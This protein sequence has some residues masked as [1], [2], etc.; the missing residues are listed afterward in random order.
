MS[1]IVSS[2]GPP[3]FSIAADEINEFTL[4]ESVD[5]MHSQCEDTQN[6]RLRSFAAR[7]NTALSRKAGHN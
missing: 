3:R 2:T 7:A 5:E 1:R 4:S 6:L